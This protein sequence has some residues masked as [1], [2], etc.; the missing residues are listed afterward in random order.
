M[1]KKPHVTRFVE[2]LAFQNGIAKSVYDVVTRLLEKM[3]W[4]PLNQV[5]LATDGGLLV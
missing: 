2:F 4:M 3:H 5:I 1:E